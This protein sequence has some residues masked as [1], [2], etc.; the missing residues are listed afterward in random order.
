MLQVE[1]R[2]VQE[3]ERRNERVIAPLLVYLF[4]RINSSLSTL[5]PTIIFLDE[6]WFYLQHP[7]FAG[8]IREWLQ[9][10]RKLNAFV[11]FAT[12]SLTHVSENRGMLSSVMDNA[13]T[14][15]FLPNF[16]AN[17]EDMKNL[18]INTFGLSE[19]EYNMV[20]TGT[21]KKEYLIKQETVTRLA[22]L[23]LDENITALIQSDE[24]ARRLA[25]SLELTGGPDWFLDYVEHYKKRTPLKDIEDLSGYFIN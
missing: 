20:V 8:K 10:L 7:I 14:K 23:N 5:V 24:Y 2:F 19:N 15:I 13:A 22:Q 25:K 9:T 21:Q 16:K 17:T 3:Y 12:Q 1:P 4:E 6:S 18:Y 11:V